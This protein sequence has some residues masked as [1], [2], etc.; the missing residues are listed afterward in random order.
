M[1]APAALPDDGADADRPSRQVGAL[2]IRRAARGGIEVL[3]VTSR[4]SGRWIVPKGWPMPGLSDSDAAAREALEEAGVTG[5]VGENPVG[6]FR[7][8]KGR[9]KDAQ[10]FE[11]ALYQLDVSGQRRRWRERGQRKLRWASPE[12]AAKLVAW[13]GLAS[14]IRAVGASHPARR[15]IRPWLRRL[16]LRL[17]RPLLGEQGNQAD[18]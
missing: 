11:V 18:Q 14:I 12:R 4:G 9:G 15:G 17:A 10:E 5:R 6:S 16:W 7:Y 1:T 8:A 3:L 2:P 13:P